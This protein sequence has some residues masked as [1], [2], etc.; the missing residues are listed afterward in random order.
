MD[1][2]IRVLF[3]FM[4]MR[5]IFWGRYSR[6]VEGDWGFDKVEFLVYFVSFFLDFKF[7]LSYF[8]LGWEEGLLLFMG[9]FFFD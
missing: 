1:V 4:R 9:K 7:C 6:N 3:W 5:V 8:F 2:R